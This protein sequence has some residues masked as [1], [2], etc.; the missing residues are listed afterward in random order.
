MY[1]EKRPHL[2]SWQ[3]ISIVSWI[4]L[5]SNIWW[6]CLFFFATELKSMTI[7]YCECTPTPIRL[8]SLGLFPC[9]PTAP[10]L[11]VD[12]NMLNFAVNFFY[13]SGQITRGGVKHWKV[14]Y[15]CGDIS[16]PLRYV[17]MYFKISWT[18][19]LTSHSRTHFDSVLEMRF[20]GT[21]A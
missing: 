21:V 12:L 9:A 15:Q 17:I 19:R 20:F 4:Y 8:L 11:A 2:P 13:E 5:C 14:S 1:A 3:F 10:T 16:S 18:Y 7:M 6:L